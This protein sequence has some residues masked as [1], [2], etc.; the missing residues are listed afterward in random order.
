MCCVTTLRAAAVLA[1]Y[2]HGYFA[3]A[4]TLLGI[5]L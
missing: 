4:F 5:Y 2:A 3:E 1:L